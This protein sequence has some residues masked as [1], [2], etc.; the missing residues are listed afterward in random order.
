MEN[1]IDYHGMPKEWFPMKSQLRRHLE[2]ISADPLQPTPKPR[3]LSN[4]LQSLL[5]RKWV[6]SAYD[7]DARREGRLQCVRTPLG[8]NAL[9]IDAQVRRSI[10]IDDDSD[11]S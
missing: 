11:W 1:E 9:E 6:V 8:D 2:S 7:P 3:T 10:D 4:Y 5:G